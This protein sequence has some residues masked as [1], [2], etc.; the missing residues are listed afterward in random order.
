MTFARRSEETLEIRHM[1]SSQPIRHQYGAWFSLDYRYQSC[2]EPQNQG[3]GVTCPLGFAARAVRL[4]ASTVIPWETANSTSNLGFL[5]RESG[6]AGSLLRGR[7]RDTEP[8]HFG[9]QCGSFESEFHRCTA[10]ATDDPAGLL[11]CFQNQSAFRVFQ[12]HR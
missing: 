7:P 2:D 3:S 12:G 8:S 9:K 10:L 5:L 6:N 4:L 1:N 11:K